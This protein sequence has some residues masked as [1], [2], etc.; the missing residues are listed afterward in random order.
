MDII[1]NEMQSLIPRRSC[2]KFRVDS[3]FVIVTNYTN[4]MIYLNG[5]ASEIFLLCDGKRSIND[6]CNKMLSEY[7][8][9]PK[10]MR[11]DLIKIIRDFQWTRI[12]KLL[13]P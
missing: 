2:Q 4:K 9:E 5:T 12:I 10:T 11:H 6:I 13:R 7:D 1:F 8:V 3:D